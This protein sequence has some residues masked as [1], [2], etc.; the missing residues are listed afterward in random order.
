M[1]PC[2]EWNCHTSTPVNRHCQ[3]CDC[4]GFSFFVALMMGDCPTRRKP[5]SDP[6]RRLRFRIF[7][8]EK[9]SRNISLQSH[10]SRRLPSLWLIWLLNTTNGSVTPFE[11]LKR[12]LAI[13]KKQTHP[14]SFFIAKITP[15]SS[16]RSLCLMY[17]DFENTPWHFGIMAQLTEF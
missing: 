12:Y 17:G 11:K 1:P 13:S 2:T 16:R 9:K 7:F 5:K 4:G 3:H 15:V 6:V 10:S 8:S 14:F